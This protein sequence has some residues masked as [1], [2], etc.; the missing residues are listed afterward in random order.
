MREYVI[1]LPTHQV[2][3]RPRRQKSET[4]LGNFR[5]SF[6]RKS[7]IERIFQGMKV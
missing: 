3:F 4:G 5:P 6:S 2:E 1:F 7:G